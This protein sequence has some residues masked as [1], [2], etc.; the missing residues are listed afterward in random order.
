MLSHEQARRVYDRIGRG[1]DS[2]A[3][4]E[5]RATAV[6]IAHSDFA[7]AG[8]VFEYG[9]GT[10]RFAQRLLSECLPATARYQGVDLSPTMIG[11][12]TQRLA[13]YSER[14]AV[15]LTQGGAPVDEP[16]GV[17]DRFVSTYVFDLLSEE[18]IAAVIHE[19]RR[20][21]RSGGL[22]CLTSLSSGVSPVTRAVSGIWSWIQA[23][24]PSLVG[25]C[26][27]IELA[28]FLAS[29]DWQMRHQSK[30]VAFGLTSEIIVAARI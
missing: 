11:L 5:D 4:Y 28:P 9:C 23:R 7:A 13:A 15:R 8:A 20:M 6:L 18:D 10:G 19:A 24:Q 22:L 29:A 25:G 2:Q 27:P 12:A 17:Y 1:Q 16:A 30:V 21:L 14:A 3:F 26:R